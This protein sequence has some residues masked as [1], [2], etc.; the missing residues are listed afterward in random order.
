MNQFSRL[1]LAACVAL[2]ACRDTTKVESGLH[3]AL[4]ADRT[5]VDSAHPL[6]LTVTVTNRSSRDVVTP[7]PR[8]YACLPTYVVL[9]EHGTAVAPVARI[10]SA[11]AY[12]PKVLAPGETMEVHDRW[13]G[14]ASGGGLTA[15]AAPAGQ[16]HIVAQVF[17]DGIV[18][19]SDT[20]VVSV[21]RS[22]S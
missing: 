20:V 2:G 21:T 8:N 5:V 14:D 10:C 17:G 3:V 1:T 6:G 16:Y 18:S 15:I 9:N 19:T 12:A 11:I 22:G 13:S 4:R 7:D